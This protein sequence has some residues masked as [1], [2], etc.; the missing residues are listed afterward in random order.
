MPN[1]GSIR[2]PVHKRGDRGDL[3]FLVIEGACSLSYWPH[4]INYHVH[5]Y[6]YI[7]DKT[8]H[9]KTLTDFF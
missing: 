1:R 4:Y 2:P 6:Q 9:F 5:I 7:A 8:L 3:T